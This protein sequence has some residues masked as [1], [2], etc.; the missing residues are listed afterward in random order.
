[1]TRGPNPAR[2]RGGG[3]PP[4]RSTP[5]GTGHARRV[6]AWGRYRR[7]AD[8]RGAR[9]CHHVDLFDLD[10]VAL[11]RSAQDIVENGSGFGERVRLD[12]KNDGGFQLHLALRMIAAATKSD[13]QG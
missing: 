13:E 6:L 10:V 11:L 9:R 4:P 1:M 2:C 7:K 8:W 3:L 12:P 5:P